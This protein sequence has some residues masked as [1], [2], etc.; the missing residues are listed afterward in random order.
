MNELVLQLREEFHTLFNQIPEYGVFAPGRV[1]LIGEHTDYTGGFVMP[2]ALDIGTY[3]L[4]GRRTD[5]KLCFYSHNFKDQGVY[6]IELNQLDFDSQHD[7]ANYPKGILKALER[8]GTLFHKGLNLY[9]YGNI[10][11]GAG[12]S[13]SASIE[14]AMAVLA[15]E[16]YQLGKSQIDLVKLSKKVENDYIGVNCGIMDQF[17]IGLAKN[18]HCMILNTDTLS[19]EH[20]PLFDDE[21]RVVIINS[22]VQRSLSESQYNQRMK[23]VKSA[24][25]ILR[26]KGIQQV[27]QL[28]LE[29]L[30][31][32]KQYLEEPLMY[33]K[34]KHIITENHRV[35]LAAKMLKHH[36]MEKLG[37]LMVESHLSLKNDFEVSIEPLDVLVEAC[38]KHGALGARMTGAG[39]GGC[40]IALVKAHHL[41]SFTKQVSHDYE[42]VVKLKPDIYHVGSHQGATTF[43]ISRDRQVNQLLQYGL[44][45]KL[46]H[47]EDAIY[48]RNQ[49]L[50]ILGWDDYQ[51][52]KGENN[53]PLSIEE[54]IQPLLNSLV[55]HHK[56]NPRSEEEKDLWRSKLFGILTKK[57]SEVIEQFNTYKKENIEQATNWLYQFSIDTHYIR[58]DR[59]ALNEQWSV[60]TDYG[61]IEITINL[62]KPEK[63]IQQIVEDSVKT[64]VDY[65]QCLLCIDNEGYHGRIGH[66][67]RQN[68][69]LIPM[70]L[71]QEDFYFQ[72][73]PYGYY[74]EH[75]IVLTKKHRPM[76]IDQT[77]F[78]KIFDFLD[79]MPHYFIGSNCDL[80][81]VGGSI[82]SHD[83]FQAGRYVFP[84][85]KAKTQL[86]FTH[87]KYQDMELSWLKWP[88]TV[89]RLGSKNREEL[90]TVAEEIRV[91]WADYDNETLMIRHGSDKT[92]HNGIT[93][94]GRRNQE[95][96]EL[97]IVLRNN[98]QSPEFP[99]GIFHPHRNIHHIKKENIGLIEVMG[100]AILPPRLKREKAAMMKAILGKTLTK[101][102]AK[103]IEK[104]QHLVEDIRLNIQGKKEEKDIQ[105]LVNNSIGQQFVKGLEH[106]GVFKQ[107][108]LGR[109][110]LVSWLKT[111]GWEIRRSS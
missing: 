57:P 14:M 63:D 8:E 42:Q 76:K 27:G 90:E 9:F 51:A 6:E 47:S 82:L 39:F 70:Q 49:I 65:P 83:H 54:V 46:I 36:N 33:K 19:Y 92:Q 2:Y 7:W 58:E 37:E 79:E 18:N 107:D 4:A 21:Y 11:N 48:I 60:D 40:V 98:R 15:N 43:L 74:Q 38:L 73:S 50:S 99:E 66:P 62:S 97:D 75:S 1:N 94:I 104:H 111:L 68:L 108:D 41:E 59:M 101:E 78:T 24:E 26:E 80:P 22:M 55:Y 100:L 106:A 103:H 61:Q 95:V 13:S 30:D 25:H 102:E 52:I 109:H 16:I 28:S 34:I 91:A 81:I 85:E 84:V 96:Y 89:L 17:I 10:P 71:G 72:Y 12:L 5:K 23:E 88:L 32:V 110:A 86:S 56:L 3:V 29:D 64:T 44:Q 53:K 20:I 69:R 31:T 45:K 93:P 35:H 77:T 87:L 105:D 67:G